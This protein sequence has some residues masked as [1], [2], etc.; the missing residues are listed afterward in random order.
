[1]IMWWSFAAIGRGSSEI[2]RWKKKKHHEHFI[3]PPVTTVNG[4]PKYAFEVPNVVK[5]VSRGYNILLNK[6]ISHFSKINVKIAYFSAFLQAEM[7]S[8]AVASKQN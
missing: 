3:C 1:M 4:R 5:A 2:T 6:S 8:F 7:I